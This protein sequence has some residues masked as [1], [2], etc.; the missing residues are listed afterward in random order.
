[1]RRQRGDVRAAPEHAAAADLGVAHDGEQKRRFA[2]AV[3]PEHG[4]PA[5]FGELERHAVEHHGG[6]IAGAD[7][8]KRQQ[9]R[10][11]GASPDRFFAGAVMMALAEI[12]RAHARIGRDLGRR[13]FGEHAA[14]DHAR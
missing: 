6:A 7:V 11:H 13:A 8:V 1:M 9:Q 12:D 14:A 2:D 4:K 5:A 3:P 10:G